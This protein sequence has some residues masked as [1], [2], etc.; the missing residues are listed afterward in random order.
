MLAPVVINATGAWADDLRAQVGG[1]RRLRRLR[2]SHL[3]FP[4]SRLPLTR[5]VSVLHP[6]TGRPV[7][8]VPWEGV[9]LIGTTD[10]DHTQASMSEPAIDAAE[11]QLPAGHDLLRLPVP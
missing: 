9:T 8:A 6:A 11:A 1:P 4:F 3:V 7:F 2:G 10:V 5:A